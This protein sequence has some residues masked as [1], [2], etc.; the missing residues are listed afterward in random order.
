MTARDCGD[1]VHRGHAR[2][3]RQTRRPGR[4]ARRP[5]RHPHHVH[6]A[7]LPRRRRPRDVDRRDRRDSRSSPGCRVALPGTRPRPADHPC[8]RWPDHARC[9]RRPRDLSGRGTSGRRRRHV[10]DQGPGTRHRHDGCRPDPALLG[11]SPRLPGSGRLPGRP[12]GSRSVD[13]VPADDRT[14][15]RTQP[16]PPRRHRAPRRGR[17]T[18]APTRSPPAAHCSPTS[19][20]DRGGCSPTPTATRCACR[21]WRDR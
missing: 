9:R 1:G 18:R 4:L 17:A 6:R 3:I 13:L 21:T 5:R 11:R 12:D 19:T 20:P 15:H 10:V 8:D 7:G 2:G 14:A 16:H